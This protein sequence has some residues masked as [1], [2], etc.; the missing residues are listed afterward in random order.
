[1]IKAVFYD[2]EGN[3]RGT[4]MLSEIVKKQ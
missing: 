2:T 4:T 3:L 1:V